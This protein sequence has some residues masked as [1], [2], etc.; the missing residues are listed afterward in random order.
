MKEQG[1]THRELLKIGADQKM[2]TQDNMVSLHETE[3]TIAANLEI[4]RKKAQQ[5]GVPNNN[6]PTTQ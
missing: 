1:A 2:N 3:I 5:H 4:E 6:R